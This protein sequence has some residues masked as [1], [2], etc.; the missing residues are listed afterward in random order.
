MKPNFPRIAS[1]SFLLGL[2]ASLSVGLAA[3]HGENE[4]VSPE[5]RDVEITEG[6]AV[7]IE[8]PDGVA[9]EQIHA[10]ASHVENGFGG[11]VAAAKVE[12]MAADDGAATM[13]VELWGSGLPEDAAL[14]SGLVAKFPELV[15]AVI[16]IETLDESQGPAQTEV[17]SDAEDPEVA[18]Q[19]IEDQLRA[20]GV[21]GDI[22]VD[23]E[24]GPEG[25]RVE[26]QVEDRKPD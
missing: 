4:Y 26:V 10:I 1:L 16:S 21:E 8:L 9:D 15:G 23:V 22:H 7:S 18:R 5:P 3:C 17:H 11:D 12:V 24:D 2:S 20:Q 13:V 14:K 25:R 6:R 19:E